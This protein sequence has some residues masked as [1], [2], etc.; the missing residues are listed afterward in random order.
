MVVRKTAIDEVGLLDEDY[1]FYLEE[2]DWCLRFKKQGWKIIHYPGSEIYHR[3][4]QSVKK[5]YIKGRIEYWKSRYIFFR[6][7]RGRAARIALRTGLL[8]RI[9]LNFLLLVI[10]NLAVFFF[11]RKSR[12]KLKLYASLIVW[13]LAGCPESWGLNPVQ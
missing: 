7:H 8:I 1:F 5:E 2:T 4:G 6:K 9:W 3:Q 13:H 11:H 10:C 12:Q